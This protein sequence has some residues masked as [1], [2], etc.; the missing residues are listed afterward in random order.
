MAACVMYRRGELLEP[1]DALPLVARLARIC[2]RPE[3]GECNGSAQYVCI[4][5]CW[6]RLAV[7][8]GVG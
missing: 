7:V 6:K 3:L 4:E 5:S 8:T 1:D 2:K